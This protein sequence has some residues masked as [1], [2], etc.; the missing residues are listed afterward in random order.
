MQYIFL[1]L[2][3]LA[4]GPLSAAE[5][6]HTSDKPDTILHFAIVPQQSPRELAKRWGPIL[7]YISEHSGVSLQFQTAN[8]LTTYQQ[9]MKTGRYDICFYEC[10]LLCGVQQ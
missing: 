2:C 5:I 6:S 4:G 10:L 9:E 8:S 3:L 7:Q 1:V